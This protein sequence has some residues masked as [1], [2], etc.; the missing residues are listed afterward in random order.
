MWVQGL[1]A[2]GGKEEKDPGETM[3]WEKEEE[4]EEEEERPGGV[5]G[6]RAEGGKEYPQFPKKTNYFENHPEVRLRSK[7]SH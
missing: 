5:W 7:C 3:A 1:L 4:E 2:R 6:L